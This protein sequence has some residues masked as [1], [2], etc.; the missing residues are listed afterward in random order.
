MIH[1]RVKQ[2]VGKYEL[3][4]VRLM[5][6]TCVHEDVDIVFGSSDRVVPLGRRPGHLDKF[7]G[8][9]VQCYDEGSNH[10]SADGCLR[11]EEGSAPRYGATP[12]KRIRRWHC[13]KCLVADIPSH[14]GVHYDN[15]RKK[16]KK[17][18]KKKKKKI[19]NYMFMRTFR[20]RAN[21]Q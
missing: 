2:S 19:F 13:Y 14:F 8:I 16:K 12:H 1:R 18:K 4:L 10:V 21:Q 7:G 15:E 9:S 20:H 11:P 6:A 17:A 3:D 5:C